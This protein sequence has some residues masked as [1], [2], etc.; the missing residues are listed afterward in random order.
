MLN[1][2]FSLREI[3]LHPFNRGQIF[4][5]MIRLIVWKIFQK[6]FA[7]D[8]IVGLKNARKML[9]PADSSYGSIIQYTRGYPDL[10][11]TK[12]LLKV[13][14]KDDVFIDVGANIGY[15]S[16]LALGQGATTYSFEP[17]EA[18]HFYISYSAKLNADEKKLH[19]S[20]NLISDNI[21]YEQFVFEK[22]SEVSHI[23]RQQDIT[24]GKKISCTTLDEVSKKY[25][26]KQIQLLKIDAEGAEP[27]VFRGMKRILNKKIVSYVLF[28]HDPANNLDQEYLSLIYD[29]SLKKSLFTIHHH[30]IAPFQ[31]TDLLSKK[32]FFG[33]FKD[34]NIELSDFLDLN[35][36][37]NKQV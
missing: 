7:Q 37:E 20:S 15:Y 21:G 28:E 11:E 29:L 13:L 8:V 2:F 36:I 25:Q 16:I 26:L 3:L 34:K 22:E 1:Y 17:N 27:L 35:T 23:A 24:K 12:I 4:S 31:E 30:N 6:V 9:I 18:L 32:N 14:K 19:L 5:T 33:S 10:I